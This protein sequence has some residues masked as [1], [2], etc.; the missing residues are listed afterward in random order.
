MINRRIWQIGIS[1][2]LLMFSAGLFVK[3]RNENHNTNQ[4]AVIIDPDT[5]ETDLS[6]TGT[7]ICTHSSSIEYMSYPTHSSLDRLNNK[8]GL[9]I[10]AEEERFF[11]LADN[12][13]N[14]GGGDWGYV[15][16]PYNVK[17]R[18]TKKWR[19][20]FDDLTERH[21]IPIVQLWDVDTKDYKNATKD[22]A[23]FLNGFLWPVKER[24]ISAY[25]E[26]N[27]DRF[28]KGDAN[29][30]NYAQV[31]NYT[32]DTFKKE[33]SNFFMLNGALNSSAP[34]GNGYIGALSFLYQMNIAVPGIFNKLDGWASH[35]YPQPNFAGS[36]YATGLLSVRAYETELNYLKNTLGVTKELPVFITETGWAHAEGENYNASFYNA[37]QVAQNFKIAFEEVWLKDDRVRAVTPFTVYYKAPFDHFSWINEDSVPYEQYEVLKKIN[38]I[39]GKP[40][41]LIK[42]KLLVSDCRQAL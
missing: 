31:L 4:E 18:D 39:K 23:Q 27:D 12:L 16:I 35:S 20:V 34:D 29:A 40:A 30:K 13:V 11:K 10:Y 41:T 14:S 5:I 28:W 25:N 17:D 1:L 24:Y 7:G 6:T 33:N 22:A 8:F 19:R 9:Y 38:K 3:M 2:V 42:T 32:I 15:L 36:P 26:P 21:L 37:S